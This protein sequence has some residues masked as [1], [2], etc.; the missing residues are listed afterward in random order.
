MNRMSFAALRAA[1]V[2]VPFL[3]SL[4]SLA[5]NDHEPAARLY[6]QV[7]LSFEAN[8]G[9]TDAQV[10]Y[11]SRG[12]GYSLFLTRNEAVLALRRGSV[13]SAERGLRATVSQSKPAMEKSGTDVVRMRLVGSNSGTPVT[14]LDQLP[15]SANY[16]VGNDPK[17][18]RS[19]VPTY[20][21]VKYEGVYPGVDL[22]YYG[23]QRQLEYDFVV[24]PGADPSRVRM[25]FQGVKRVRLD[26]NGNLVVA[27]GGSE[28]VFE[29]PTIY[30]N[31]DGV[32]KPVDGRF[33]LLASHAIGFA[34]GGYDHRRALVIDPVLAY[35]TFLSGN[36]S[37]QQIGSLGRAIAVDSSGS[38]YITGVTSLVD[39]PTTSGSF[40]S[41][42]VGTQVNE[43]ESYPF[44]AKLNPT[45]TALVYTTYLAGSETGEEG[46]G[47]MASG[48]SVDASGDAYVTGWAFSDD[49]PVTGDAFQ[50]EKKTTYYF[51]SN[52]FLTKLNPT[53]TGL[54]YSTYLG[55]TSSDACVQVTVNSSGNAY[56]IGTAES[57]DFPVTPG[58]FMTGEP[59]YDQ[60]FVTEF[61]PQGS[62]LV[63]STYL[64]GTTNASYAHGIA[65]DSAGN[66]YVTGQT[67]ATDFPDTANGYQSVNKA[68]IARDLPTGFVAKL[69]PS[70]SA[71]AFA[72]YLGGSGTD[73]GRYGDDPA[74]IAF[75][76]S[77]NVYVS[78]MT[79]SEDFPVT[80]AAFQNS[81]L[82]YA[83]E[84]YPET[85]TT[86]FVTKLNPTG[87]SLIFSTYVGSS[88]GEYTVTP[89]I[90]D[91]YNQGVPGSGGMALDSNGNV[92]FTGAT[93]GVNY[94][95]TSNA[96]QSVNNAS[97]SSNNGLS[98]Y[99]TDAFVTELSSSGALVYST[100]LGGSGA[101]YSGNVGD[102]G[103]SIA[104]DSSGNIYVTGIATSYDFP[105]TS[106]A[107]QTTKTTDYSAFVSK[108]NPNGS[109]NSTLTT[110]VSSN[111]PQAPV[112]QV[113]FA[114]HVQSTSALG[115]PTGSVSFSFDG[116]SGAVVS[117]DA[118]G[119]A[120]Y[121]TTALAS[122]VHTVTATYS[123]DS[124]FAA[125]GNTMT[126]VVPGAAANVSIVSG[127]N[128]T[129]YP[130]IPLLK[131][132]VVL[133]TDANGTPVPGIYVSFGGPDL[134]YTYIQQYTNQ[135]GEFAVEVTPTSYN[136]TNPVVSGTASVNGVNIPAFFS[137]TV[138]PPPTPATPKFS[139]ASGSYCSAQI[140]ILTDA[141]PGV[142]IYYTTDGSI[143]S[144]YSTL[145]T[146]PITVGQ[147]E[148]VQAIAAATGYNNSAIVRESIGIGQPQTITFSPLP[149]TIRINPNPIKLK[150]TASSDL[151]VT[152]SMVSGPGRISSNDLYLTG[153]GKVVVAASQS[154]SATYCKATKDDMTLVFGPG[155]NVITFPKPKSP[156]IYGVAPI[157][158][159]AKASS[160]L[161]V[162]YVVSGP[163]KIIDSHYLK[164]TGTGTIEVTAEQPGNA[165][166]SKAKPVKWPI[167]VDK[168]SSAVAEANP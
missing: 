145:Y 84:N 111:N 27:A 109:N 95:T 73:E 132:I 13:S 24:A 67:Y 158:L 112:T 9:Q 91:S 155:Y 104:L 116:G 30:Q 66:A 69:K 102:Y 166:Y 120:S 15:G 42:L 139:L 107:F 135:A 35:S 164:V 165:D 20:G 85:Y 115:I 25:Q 144:A 101:Y 57:R 78:G 136:G 131:P 52:C 36:G 11:L 33:K 4:G 1:A 168:K 142:Q 99:S 113:T 119:L 14:G 146:G 18:W 58:A 48:I 125:S 154:G 62:G 100:Y 55:G 105:A 71:L 124:N 6:G 152:F 122:G 41:A 88:A 70:G 159:T 80:P 29:K 160:D 123:G 39:F 129:G 16:F 110:L 65:V 98:P 108:I 68:T 45:G 17:K 12:N 60:A 92:Y 114:S 140:L 43:G 40:Q 153:L 32:P 87:S 28:V 10:R 156:V 46:Y 8:Q 86:G 117:L 54:I 3:L 121:P 23:N 50:S 93:F 77:G 157:D 133:A 89:E 143:P 22:I 79:D 149:G 148:T 44:V 137:V 163:G 72:T 90:Y 5:Q 97:Q 162:K 130:N 147:S 53:G 59:N 128:Q 21:K 127:N 96:F 150:A 74:A 126:E 76:S 141:T 56:V 61:N 34:I 103:S 94:P 26:R 81:N 7:P 63:Y 167:V 118:N 138:Q 31:Q 151:E 83:A 75:D 134:S 51:Y 82:T 2:C 47:D 106:G 64:G 19:G 49:F 37:S 38:A 161:A